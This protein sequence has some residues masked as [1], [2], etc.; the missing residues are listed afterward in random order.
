MIIYKKISTVGKSP[1]NFTKSLASNIADI[2]LHSSL[3]NLPSKYAV[4]FEDIT[5]GSEVFRHSVKTFQ[6][7]FV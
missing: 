7:N 5:E 4:W 6:T 1:L 2:K 3:I